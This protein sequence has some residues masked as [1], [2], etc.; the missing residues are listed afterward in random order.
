MAL[1]GGGVPANPLPPPLIP[2]PARRC[3]PRHRPRGDAPAIQIDDVDD[4][5]SA[6]SEPDEEEVGSLKEPQEPEARPPDNT[7]SS[8]GCT[9]SS[10][11]SAEPSVLVQWADII[12]PAPAEGIPLPVQK[13]LL[14]AEAQ[15]DGVSWTPP[16]T[17]DMPASHYFR[18]ATAA[19]T[20]GVCVAQTPEGLLAG[21]RACLGRVERSRVHLSANFARQVPNEVLAVPRTLRY[22]LRR[23]WDGEGC[24]SETIDARGYVCGPSPHVGLA[25]APGT[26]THHFP[27]RKS[28]PKVVLS[29]PRGVGWVMLSQHSHGSM[30][31]ESFSAP[32][33]P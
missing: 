25:V 5:E 18:T 31:E 20:V 21:L 16:L 33:A 9:K 11:S 3:P 12:K 4:V 10:G 8:A 23:G 13:M 17:A 26:N 1:G 15:D 19:A 2:L 29:C 22:P 14:S 27:S 28:G 32:S 7:S 30:Q 24:C 6:A